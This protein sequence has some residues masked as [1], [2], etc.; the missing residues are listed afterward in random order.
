MDWLI[1]GL[2]N[3][4]PKYAGT[5]HNI[6]FQVVNQLAEETGLRFDDQR[7][8]SI[9]ARGRIDDISV[10]LMKPLTFMN[11]SGEAVGAIAR[12]YKIPPAHILIIYDDLDLDSAKLRLRLK[13]GSGGQ[14][15]M[16]SIIQHLG[17]QDFPR[18][19]V[20]IGRPPGRMPVEA[21]VLQKF[22]ND[23]WV[24]MRQTIDDAIGAIRLLIADG[25][26]KAMNRYN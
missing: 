13:G 8:K 24:T 16:K 3:P 5:R 10:A 19:R 22:S 2:G 25:V 17:G 12:F 1:V 26:E 23:E 4:G 6:G 11:K 14:K 7:N 9:L 18:M 20:G 15:G 21:Y